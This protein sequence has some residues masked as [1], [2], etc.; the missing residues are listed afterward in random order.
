MAFIALAAASAGCIQEA[1]PDGATI[2]EEPDI[3]SLLNGLPASMTAAGITGFYSSTGYHVD[4]GIPSIHIMTETMLE[5]LVLCGEGGYFQYNNYAMN[6]GQGPTGAYASYYW[7]AYYQYIRSANEII[8]RLDSETEDPQQ[9]YWLGQALTYRAMC[10]LDLARLYEPKQN[11]YVPVTENILG[12]T[13]PVVTEE[14]TKEQASRNPR[15]S[16]ED[17]YAFI[18]SDLS[19]AEESFT[20]AK[21]GGY[22]SSVTRPGLHAVRALAARAYIEM[23][24]WETGADPEAFSKVISNADEVIAAF[25]P[26]TESQWHDPSTGF[27][28]ANSN[29]SWVWGLT[30]DSSMTNN[31]FNFTAMMAVEAQF[32]YAQFTAPGINSWL[33]AQASDSDFR[34]YT[35]YVK[36]SGMP[37]R[38]AGTVENGQETAA[39]AVN[40]QSFKF[41]PA[42]GNCVDYSVGVAADH[43][44]IRVEELHFLKMEAVLREQGVHAAA[45][46][47]EDFLNT[48]RYTDGSYVCKAVTE[49]EFID[50]MMVHKRLEFWG[51]GILIYD[52][53]RLDRGITRNYKGTNNYGDYLL[54]TTGR[55]PQWNFCIPLSEMQTNLA[56]TSDLNNPDPTSFVGDPEVS[57]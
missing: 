24:Y 2:T 35:W 52:Y 11:S 21:A 13:V 40:Y 47:L 5:D 48:Y 25:T 6:L 42:M 53:K 50:E 38:F 34:K 12:L 23:G 26:L 1:Q 22:S 10:Y 54:N 33:Y 18:L 28:K 14:T 57:L 15:A 8:A 17:M 32:G 43:P 46:L 55:S 37:Y 45:K 3:E 31:L 16:R 51:E 49:D 56:I 39:Y 19:K 36:G 41:R 27:N 44:L 9:R 30:L 29:S 4:F 20:M 7:L